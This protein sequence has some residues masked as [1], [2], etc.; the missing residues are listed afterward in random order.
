GMVAPVPYDVERKRASYGGGR[1]GHLLRCLQFRLRWLPAQ[2]RKE[3][4]QS[5]SRLLDAGG[6]AKLNQLARIDGDGK[7]S[8]SLHQ[9]ETS[10]RYICANFYG[11]SSS[12]SISKEN[13]REVLPFKG[14][15]R[16][17]S[18]QMRV[19]HISL[20]VEVVQGKKN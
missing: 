3:R 6:K 4:P 7:S 16:K 10:S 11:Q 15:C 17:N 5:G 12:S 14:S 1:S 18:H 20:L 9:V 13:G 8:G 19:T 2:K